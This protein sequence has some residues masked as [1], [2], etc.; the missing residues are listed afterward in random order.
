[1]MTD[2]AGVCRTSLLI[3][4]LRCLSPGHCGIV[5]F[6]LVDLEPAQAMLTNNGSDREFS[7]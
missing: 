3:G 1:M 4:D 7:N 5:E 2:A 6:M